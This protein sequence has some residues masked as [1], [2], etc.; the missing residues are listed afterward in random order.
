MKNIL[1]FIMY[2]FYKSIISNGFLTILDSASAKK[3]TPGERKPSGYC[4]NSCICGQDGI[5]TCTRRGCY[6]PTSSQSRKSL[7]TSKLKMII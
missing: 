3:C 2:C 6:R 5:Y 4:G 1:I 7:S